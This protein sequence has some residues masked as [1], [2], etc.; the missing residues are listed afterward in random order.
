[1]TKISKKAWRL[2]KKLNGDPLLLNGKPTAKIKR[3]KLTRSRDTE[4][5]NF[6]LDFTP[7]ELNESLKEMKNRKAPRVDKIMT[8]QIKEFSIKSKQWLLTFLNSCCDKV[9]VPKIP[10]SLLCHT[11]KLYERMIM[12]H[13]K[14]QVERKLIPE[15]AGFRPGK[16]CTGLVLNL[17]QYIKDGY[18]NKKAM[19]MI[20]VLFVE[21]VEMKLVKL[22]MPFCNVDTGGV[23]ILVVNN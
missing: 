12:N 22:S 5:N 18:E 17:C 13:I 3:G 7:D 9:L 21:D 6:Q 14:C 2:I 11:F 15:Q 16:N 8:E 4:Q 1:M 23:V 10:I 20:V 19:N